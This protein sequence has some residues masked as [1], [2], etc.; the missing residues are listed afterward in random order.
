MASSGTNQ[1]QASISHPGGILGTAKPLFKMT[2][3]PSQHPHL[4]VHLTDRALTPVISSSQQHSSSPSKPRPSKQPTFSTSPPSSS[5][6]STTA[7]SS[8][9][10]SP[11]DDDDEAE[12]VPSPASS[13]SLLTS[14]ALASYDTAKRLDRGA[15]LRTM[16][17]Y[18]GDAAAAVTH[19]ADKDKDRSSARGGPVVLH[20]YMCPMGL[21]LGVPGNR[22]GSQGSLTTGAGVPDPDPAGAGDALEGGQAQQQHEAPGGGAAAAEHGRNGKDKHVVEARQRPAALLHPPL[23]IY[24]DDND[25]EGGGGG[26]AGDG[27]EAPNAPPMLISTVVAPSAEYLRDARRAA[28]RLERLA[29][30]LQAEWVLSE[31]GVV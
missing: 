8:S 22:R 3:L 18:A 27:G 7:S 5:P 10:S 12:S 16:V 29:R 28:D 4:A 14:T 19:P 20:S 1:Y 23:Q 13:L 31:G 11:D 24:K 15:P 21:A 9:S 6:E 2:T 26:G 17:E 30:G 25:D